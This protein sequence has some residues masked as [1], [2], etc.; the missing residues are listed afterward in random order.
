[1]LRWLSILMVPL[2]AI[3]STPG[4]SASPQATPASEVD[5][6]LRARVDGYWAAMRQEL[7]SKAAEFVKPDERD[8]FIAAKKSPMISYSIDRMVLED[9]MTR[10]KVDV[11]ITKVII[12]LQKPAEFKSQ[13][14]WE[15]INGEWYITFDK[16]GHNFFGDLKTGSMIRNPT[17]LQIGSNRDGD[18]MAS[19]D[20]D[21][22]V[23]NI[24]TTE[25]PLQAT[26]DF[27]K[28]TFAGETVNYKFRF[29]NIGKTPLKVRGLQTTDP[30]MSIT[31]VGS[32]NKPSTKRQFNPKEVGEVIVVFNSHGA[33]GSIEHSATVN[34]EGRKMP[35]TLGF[36]GFVN[37]N[38]TLTPGKAEIGTPGK[39]GTEIVIV[40]ESGEFV[41]VTGVQQVP[42]FLDTM[43]SKGGFAPRDQ[44]AFRLAIKPNA[45]VPPA[46]Y[47]GT[48]LIKTDLG[49]QPTISIPVRIRGVNP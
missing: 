30:S 17:S 42:E 46:G 44:A 4:L 35:L 13:H 27:G 26:Y 48:I 49:R 47:E 16:T 43:M 31:L 34:F 8:F 32:D 2:L 15:R 21:R 12:R 14:V 23:I 25:T 41:N 1:M 37:K 18:K 36:K 28:S 22:N 9:N 20:A 6:R 19:N 5:A 33:D 3:I 38:F 45:K 40:N 7:Y 39:I 10:A 11:T 29:K 24:D